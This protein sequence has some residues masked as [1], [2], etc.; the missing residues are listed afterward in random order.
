MSCLMNVAR[1]IFCAVALAGPMISA[2]PGVAAEP[3]YATHLQALQK[4]VPKGFTITLQKPF[5]VIGDEIPSLVRQRSTNT[6]KWAVE[7]LK[8]DYFSRAPDEIIDVWLFQNKASYEKYTKSLFD[9][10]PDTPFG[11]YSPTHHALIMNISTGGGT[12]VHEIVHP[13]MR[14]NFPQCPAWFNEGMGSLYEQ[15][16][17]EN[18]HIHGYPNWRLPALQKAIQR[19]D[20]P[21]FETMMRTSDSQFYGRT[22]I[23]TQYSH[24]YAQARYLCYYLQ[25]NGLL[26]TFY[27]EFTANVKSDPSGV[28]TLKSVLKAT[29]LK[30]FQKEWESFV[31][32]LKLD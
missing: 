25:Q 2:S 22:S 10:K 3:D 19:G 28:E 31:L 20:V 14:A 26:T 30:T 6:V 13:F 12:L 4:T 15:A 11:Y 17:E 29:D 7:M 32:K 27:R 9:D 21:P 18:G 24:H 16:G 5:V 1:S 8:K 23:G